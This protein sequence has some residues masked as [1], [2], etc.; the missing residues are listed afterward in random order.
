MPRNV[1]IAGVSGQLG[2]CIA[3][4]FVEEGWHVWALTRREGVPPQVQPIHLPGDWTD[5]A[6]DAA[7]TGCRVDVLVN[8]VG[9][10]VDPGTRAPELLQ[11]VNVELVSR[12]AQLA[13]RLRAKVFIN[14][15]SGSEYVPTCSGALTEADALN[16]AEPYAVT[17]AEGGRRAL[18][19]CAENSV[20]AAHIRLFGMYGPNE[21]AHRLLP[22]IVTAF[23]EGRHARLSAG[24]Q[25]RD[26]LHEEDIGAAVV[27]LA[28]ALA[29]G[30]AEAGIYNLGS[31]EGHT[32]RE[33]AEFATAFLRSGPDLLE[34]GAIGLRPGEGNWLVADTTKVR[35]AT[36]WF[37]RHD[38]RSGIARA[39]SDMPQFVGTRQ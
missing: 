26:W 29:S 16:V 4:A 15:G 36:S 25:V 18:S 20:A 12:L 21:R 37:P 28:I 6:L 30:K 34:F 11:M 1:L 3:R 39:I 22:T 13:G 7:T 31:G 32:V 33:F 38:L 19:Y 24:F 10:G 23:R 35:T 2:P 14:L 8:L 17:K 5:A 9:A 27:H